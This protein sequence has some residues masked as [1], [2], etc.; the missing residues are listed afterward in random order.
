MDSITE[1]TRWISK[2]TLP[3]IRQ[4]IVRRYDPERDNPLP[5]LGKEQA[6]AERKEAITR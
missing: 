4:F 5:I 6:E 3:D 1:R 2:I